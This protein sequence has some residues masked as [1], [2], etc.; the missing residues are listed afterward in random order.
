[1]EHVCQIEKQPGCAVLYPTRSDQE[2]VDVMGMVS[3]TS[4][5]RASV[6]R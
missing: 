2:N 6:M 4:L 3:P 1:M 5:S